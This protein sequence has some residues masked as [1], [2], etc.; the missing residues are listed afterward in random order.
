MIISTFVFTQK[1]TYERLNFFW[2]LP[3]ILV[4]GHFWVYLGTPNLSGFISKITFL[5]TFNFMQKI[6]KKN[7]RANSEILRC[8][9][10]DERMN[11]QTNGWT[12]GQNKNLTILPLARVSNNLWE[13]QLIELKS[14]IDL[15]YLFVMMQKMRIVI[16]YSNNIHVISTYQNQNHKVH[17][18]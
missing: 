12:E 13:G 11:G 7:W 3:K 15:P 18:N 6:R 4:S 17:I 14:K 10:M 5:W 8:Q 16:F 1:S 2:K 9:R